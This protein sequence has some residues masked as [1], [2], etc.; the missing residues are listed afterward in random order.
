MRIR[1]NAVKRN[2]PWPV[3]R[4]GWPLAVYEH[5]LAIA[6]FVLFFASWALH[7]MGGVSAFN[8]EQIQH[9]QPAISVWRYVT[10]VSVLVR[11]DAELAERVRR[12]RRDHRAVDLLASARV[13][14]IETG[15]R[16]EPRN[17]RVRW[18]LLHKVPP[19]A[20][21]PCD[22]GFCN[23]ELSLIAIDSRK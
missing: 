22:T 17:Q 1:A 19:A 16:P 11:V 10:T 20:A 9:G 6:F 18:R 14:R 13:C 4:G 8:E 3:K 21:G 12:G 2:S 23:G 5:S 15:R 7:A